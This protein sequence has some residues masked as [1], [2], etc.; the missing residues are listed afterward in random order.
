MSEP[1]TDARNAALIRLTTGPSPLIKLMTP[2]RYWIRVRGK[3]QGPFAA[4]QLQQLAERGRFSRLHEVS[5]DGTNWSRGTNFPELFPPTRDT[6]ARK[7]RLQPTTPPEPA[8]IEF[9]EPDEE[10]AQY[11]LAPTFAEPASA[12]EG[13]AG[14]EPDWFYARASQRYGPVALQELKA[15]LMAGT[16]Q[17]DDL[18]WTAGMADWVP[19]REVPGMFP[20]STATRKIDLDG[21]AARG[22]S[23]TYGG[24]FG[25]S[26]PRAAPMAV[27]SLVLGLLGLF[28]FWFLGSILAIVFGH[29][30]LRQIQQSQGRLTGRGMALAGL[31]MGYTAVIVIVVSAILVAGMV[32]LTI[33]TSPV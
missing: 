6:D 20:G 23:G 30:A 11:E 4:P 22:A 14:A 5:T 29:V 2:E 27:A 19:A 26:G 24:D 32:I 3:V 21:E 31:I 17:I 33:L 8:E 9:R 16:L 15:F 12:V 10:A 18:V 25:F 7:R 28:P 1:R 13:A